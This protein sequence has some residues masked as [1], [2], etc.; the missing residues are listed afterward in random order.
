MKAQ[1][2]FI[3]GSNIAI[4]TKK[5]CYDNYYS[6]VAV[7][8]KEKNILENITKNGYVVKN[9][10]SVLKIGGKQQ[11]KGSGIV[12]KG[13]EIHCVARKDAL[14]KKVYPEFFKTYEDALAA[15]DTECGFSLAISYN[16]D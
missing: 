10:I 3:E 15:I 7:S 13:R 5:D 4:I 2:D 9:T 1:E 14:S 16:Y 12:L 8:V 6:V 11:V